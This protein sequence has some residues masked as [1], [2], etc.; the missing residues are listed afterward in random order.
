MDQRLKEISEN[1]EQMMIGPDDTFRFHCTMCG[2]CCINREDI[3]LNPYDMY[4]ASK[5]LGITPGD[6]FNKYCEAYIGSSSS[7]V[8]V[9]LLPEGPD[10]RCPLL[11]GKRC[12]VH[13][14]KPTVC[15]LFPLGRGMAASKGEA[16]T[17]DRQEVRYFLQSI[18]CGDKSETFT[19]REYLESFGLP[20]QD[21]FTGKWFQAI[22]DFGGILRRL[23]GLFSD[24]GINAV[25][26]GILTALYIAYDTRKPFLPQFE[27]NS[28]RLKQF[29]DDAG[30]TPLS[31]FDGKTSEKEKTD[32]ASNG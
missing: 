31:V 23:R 7:M 24:Q 27:E 17:F 32:G 15:A 10:N 1:Y 26:T 30:I 12:S 8:V 20:A 13:H 16:V 19:V 11:K 4:R 14:G 22:S 6:F 5:E 29:F 25:S 9:R 18:R 28:R 21:P 2:K 3:I